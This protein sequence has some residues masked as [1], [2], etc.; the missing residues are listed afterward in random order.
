MLRAVNFRSVFKGM[1]AGLIV[2]ASVGCAANN[3]SSTGPRPTA[4][5]G[6]RTCQSIRNDLVKLDKKGV[7]GLVER[8]NAGKKL[9]K[10]QKA[11]AD[12]Y[13]QLL[14]DY[15]GARCHV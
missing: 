14:D 8:Q 1:A 11:Q 13:S 10:A 7:Q 9:S 15:L 2:F 5:T 12:L 6:G 4:L 3:G